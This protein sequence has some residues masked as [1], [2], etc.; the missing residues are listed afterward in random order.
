MSAADFIT[1][2]FLVNVLNGASLGRACLE[3]RQKFVDEQY[4][5]IYNLKTLAQFVLLGDP[6]LHPC[7]EDDPDERAR[8]DLADQTAARRDSPDGPCGAREREGRERCL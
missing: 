4:L 7:R 3:A 2:Y 8:K 1:Q 5:D 6:A